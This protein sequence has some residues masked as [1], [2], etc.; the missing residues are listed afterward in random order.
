MRLQVNHSPRIADEYQQCK[1]DSRCPS[2]RHTELMEQGMCPINLP[3]SRASC[4]C[5]K[6][7]VPIL[8]CNGRFLVIAIRQEVN[9]VC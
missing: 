4:F 2:Y 7:P 1:I 5:P 8:I 6:G 3:C 9:K